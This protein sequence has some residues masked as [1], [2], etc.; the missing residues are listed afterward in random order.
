MV[1]AGPA[2]L[3][4][5]LFAAVLVLAAAAALVVEI[6]LLLELEP[7]AAVPALLLP[8]TLAEV[9]VPAEPLIVAALSLVAPGALVVEPQPVTAVVA[10][11]LTWVV[12]AGVVLVLALVVVEYWRSEL[13]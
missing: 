13:P 3:A 7:A 8:M 5:P 1:L 6:V 12:Q 4:G 2:A 11:P 9:A 10:V